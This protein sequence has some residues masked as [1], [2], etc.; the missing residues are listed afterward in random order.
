MSVVLW[1]SLDEEPDGSRIDSVFD[2]EL[3]AF[4]QGFGVFVTAHVKGALKNNGTIVN[5]RGDEMDS[6]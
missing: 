6:G 3:N 1:L 4:L 5:F 2:F